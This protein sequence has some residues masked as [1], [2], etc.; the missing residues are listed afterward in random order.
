MSINKVWGLEDSQAY[1]PGFFIRKFF[2]SQDFEWLR[3]AWGILILEHSKS[4]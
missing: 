3:L 2:L 4:F 1:P